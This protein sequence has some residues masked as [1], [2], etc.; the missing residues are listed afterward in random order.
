[1]LGVMIPAAVLIGFIGI[2]VT[3]TE[4]FGLEWTDAEYV[5]RLQH[6]HPMVAEYAAYHFLCNPAPS[7]ALEPLRAL[8]LKSPAIAT[9]KAAVQVLQRM[10]ADAISALPDLRLSLADPRNEPIRS[11][12]D[13]AITTLDNHRATLDRTEGI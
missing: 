3:E 1:M 9:R 4:S 11:D 7:E 13:S 5:R 12:L 8:V 2:G 10:G 6:E